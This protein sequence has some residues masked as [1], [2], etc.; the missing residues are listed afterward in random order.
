[1]PELPEVQTVVQTL[2]P[3][4]AGAVIERANIRRMD[5]IRPA[6]TDL[7]AQIVGRPIASIDRRGKRIVFTLANGNRF[8]VHLGMSGR[9]TAEAADGPLPP[10]THIVL[11]VLQRGGSRIQL[12]LCDPRRFGGIW[13]LGRERPDRDIGPEPL[14]LPAAQLTRRLARTRRTI[15]SALLD[16]RLVAGIGNIYA[17]ESLFAAGIH[18][19]AIACELSQYQAKRLCRAIKAT[20]KR[21]LRHGGSTVRDYRDA[22]GAPGGFQR[23]HR[24]Y[25]RTGMPCVVCGEAVCRIVIGGRSTHYCPRCQ[26]ADVPVARAGSA[27]RPRPAQARPAARVRRSVSDGLAEV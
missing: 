25:G 26:A 18:P 10:H 6:G 23:L 19:L 24:V 17:D 3:Y 7:A 21:A 14:T 15:K 22:T 2:R 8:Y 12:R 4:V 20:L 11:D 5:I 1:M 9:L 27:Q 13:W 16:Q